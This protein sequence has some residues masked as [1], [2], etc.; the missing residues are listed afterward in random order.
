MVKIFT[1][2]KNNKIEFTEEELKS[3]LDE[4]YKEGL[5]DGQSKNYVYV[6]PN[7]YSDYTRGI[8]ITNETSNPYTIT[9]KDNLENPY[10]TWSSQVQ[11]WV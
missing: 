8:T 1:K 6:T 7:W 3:L 4:V 10:Y 5:N 11:D 2:N 9:G